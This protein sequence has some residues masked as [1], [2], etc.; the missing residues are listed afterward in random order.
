MQP[1]LFLRWMVISESHSSNVAPSSPFIQPLNFIKP[2]LRHTRCTSEAEDNQQ[3][4]EHDHSAHRESPFEQVID[5]SKRALNVR[6]HLHRAWNL[7]VPR[8]LTSLDFTVLFWRPAL[9]LPLVHMLVPERPLLLRTLLL[10]HQRRLKIWVGM[11]QEHIASQ[12]CPRTS[13]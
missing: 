6:H 9:W 3:S 13:S 10:H 1:A 2:R 8:Q 11:L 7:Q 5:I 12:F 4:Q